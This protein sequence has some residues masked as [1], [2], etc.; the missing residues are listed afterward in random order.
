MNFG[1]FLGNLGIFWE[2]TRGFYKITVGNAAQ[3]KITEYIKSIFL[4]KL[5]QLLEKKFI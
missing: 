1:I 2:L 5:T 3:D 4:I